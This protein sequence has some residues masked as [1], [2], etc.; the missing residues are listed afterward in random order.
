MP[1]LH[2]PDGF[3]Q[4]VF[5]MTEDGEVYKRKKGHIAVTPGGRFHL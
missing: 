4:A 1:R 5:G 3:L 2:I